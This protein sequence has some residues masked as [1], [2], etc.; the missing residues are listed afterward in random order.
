MKFVDFNK[1]WI[2]EKETNES[3]MQSFYG[4]KNTKEVNLP[5]DAM[6]REKRDKDAPAGAQS[7]FYPGGKYIYEKRFNLQDDWKDK[8]IVIEFEGVQGKSHVWVNGNLVK[9]NNNGYIGFYIELTSLLYA[10]QEN[11]IRVEVD[12]SLQPNSRWYTGSGIYRNV[13]LWLGDKVYIKNDTTKIN[14]RFLS[15]DLAQVEVTTTLKK[16]SRNSINA[17]CLFEIIED[18]EVIS[19][20]K[21]E[22]CMLS[23]EETIH[24][25]LPIENPKKWSTNNPFLYECKIS[26]QIDSEC[27]DVVRINYGLRTL[28]I[29]SKKGVLINDE[30]I[31]LR[32]TCIHH[33]NGIIGAETFIEAEDYR[34]R[35]IKEAGFNAI[36]SAHNPLSKAMLDSCDKY[37]ILVMDELTDVWNKRKN[38]YDYADVFQEEVSS[39]IQYMVNKDYNHPSVIIYSIGNEISEASTKYG[40][41]INRSLCNQFHELDHTRYTTNALNALNCAGGRLKTIMK[42]I[43][44]KF[45]GTGTTS[46]N[47]QGS[48]ALNTFMSMMSGEKGDYFAK[49]PLVS[50]ALDECNQ[51]SDII[52]LN[53]LSGRYE[54]EKELH[55]NKTVLGTETYPADIFQL[56]NLVKKNDHVIGDFT[57]TGYD[58]IGEAGV[59]IFHYD[60]SENFSSIYPE[61]LAYIGDIDIIGNRRPISYYRE[62]VFGLRTAPYIAVER[63]NHNGEQSTKTAWMFK[64]NISSWTWTGYENKVANV[65]VYSISETVELFLNGISLG[66][67]DAGE[68]NQFIASYEVPYKKGELKAVGYTNGAVDGEYVLNSADRPV[69]I[70]VEKV[71]MNEKELVYIKAFLT[72]ISGVENFLEQRKIKVEV[73]NNLLIEGYGSSNPSSEEDY[74]SDETEIYD[75][76]AM[77][78]VRIKDR[79]IK[80]K[81]TFSA[82]GLT[83][84]EIW[85]G[86]DC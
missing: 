8:D 5:Y 15:D 78:A 43:L 83:S 35:M 27:T 62:I 60:K 57:W 11:V 67:K 51:S 79:K 58:Y 45:D 6:I 13:N 53:Y 50:E 19:F 36:R 85:I 4:I 84:S 59:G 10:E 46:A 86:G 72:D 81:I 74:F 34:C 69:E 56:W 82:D 47:G 22:V 24:L 49:H 44:E 76:Y 21:Q 23:E 70:H 41:Y 1:N 77:V 16:N 17:N 30:V 32:G 80:D 52:G 9:K 54:L 7:G 38:P 28:S 12:N 37:G 20:E 63:M 65:D 26:I 33:D 2:F 64:D 39:W 73:G 66:K 55:P 71:T 42:E 25:N 18:E 75:G 29:T 40:A 68:S 61:R 48:N 31:K 3:R 14:T